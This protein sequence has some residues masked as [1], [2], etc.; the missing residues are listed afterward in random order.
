M[1]LS[2]H[3]FDPNQPRNF[4]Y[5][6]KTFLKTNIQNTYTLIHPSDFKVLQTITMVNLSPI[7]ILIEC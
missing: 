3:R 6:L 1:C 2:D 5:N 4:D 7:P